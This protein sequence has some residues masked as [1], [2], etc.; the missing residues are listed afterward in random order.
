MSTIR[1]IIDSDIFC[2]EPLCYATLAMAMA[3]AGP[4]DKCGEFNLAR[5][6]Y[7]GAY[8]RLISRL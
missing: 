5:G 8:N 2:Q 4:D 7:E 6:A 3:Y 1:A